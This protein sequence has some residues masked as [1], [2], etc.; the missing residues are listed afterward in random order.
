M[1]IIYPLGL[2]A[3]AHTPVMGGFAASVDALKYDELTLFP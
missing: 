2:E 3:G 1:V